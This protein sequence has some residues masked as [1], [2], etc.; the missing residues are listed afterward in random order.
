MQVSPMKPHPGISHP[1]HCFCQV[2]E[3]ELRYWATMRYLEQIPT[4]ELLASTDDPHAREVISI[5]SL[6]DVD[7]VT[8]LAMMGDVNQ[9]EHHVLHCREQVI[10]LL[11]L[12]R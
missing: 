10:R 5:V 12:R 1:R 2:S 4:L 9:P 3:E 6:L 8:M 11:G 7:E